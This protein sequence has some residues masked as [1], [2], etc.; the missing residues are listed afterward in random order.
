MILKE[1]NLSPPPSKYHIQK[2]SLYNLK[3]T[4]SK[5]PLRYIKL[6]HLKFNDR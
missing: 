3:H 5:I 4:E 6:S 1:A 2:M